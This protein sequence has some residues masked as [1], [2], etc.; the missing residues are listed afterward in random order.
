MPNMFGGDQQDEDYAPH[1]YYKG[2]YVGEKRANALRARD[3][4]KRKDKIRTLLDRLGLSDFDYEARG[5][6]VTDEDPW[7]IN[8]EGFALGIIHEEG[9]I[10]IKYEIGLSLHEPTI[11][12]QVELA[13]ELAIELRNHKCNQLIELPPRNVVIPKLEEII[14]Y[15]RNVVRKF[16]S[17]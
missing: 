11:L 2:K 1:F 5:Y 16:K 12:R 7:N 4:K 8:K 3:E 15:S 17:K 6:A 13:G 10:K 9:Y 14:R